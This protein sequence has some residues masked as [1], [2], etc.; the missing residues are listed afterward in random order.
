[1]ATLEP[2]HRPR[3]PS[4]Q[5]LTVHE[6]QGFA[7]YLPMVKRLAYAPDGT[8]W[9][10]RYTVAEEPQPVDI[11]D[12]DGR[13]LG[14]LPDGSPFPVGLLPDGRIL[15]SEKDQMDVERVVVRT[16]ALD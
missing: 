11:F 1:M 4:V 13:Y 16:V 7:P 9:V 14:T 5:A 8:L 12:P 15:V 6:K 2:N 10:Q 3:R